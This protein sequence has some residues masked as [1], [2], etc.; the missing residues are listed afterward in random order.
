MLRELVFNKTRIPLLYKM[1]NVAA[2][3]Q[4]TIANN[5]ANAATP[6]YRRRDVDFKEYIEQASR[7]SDSRLAT[8]Q[9]SHISGAL[10][11]DRPELDLTHPKHLNPGE[12]LGGLRV[13]ESGDTENNTGLNNVDVDTEMAELAQNQLMFNVEATLM[14]RTFRSLEKAIKGRT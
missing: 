9:R 5:I 10:Q 11:V 7:N 14:G 2:L 13:I 3:K 1:E 6:G 12:D 8:T 4:R